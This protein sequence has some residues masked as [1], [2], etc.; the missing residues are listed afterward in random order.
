V[1]DPQN[2]VRNYT[3][4]ELQELLIFCVC[5]AGKSAATIAPRVDKLFKFLQVHTGGDCPL[6]YSYA[7]PLDLWSVLQDLGIGCYRM[8]ATAIK[9]VAE[10]ISYNELNLRTCTVEELEAIHG[11]GPKTA[12]AFIMWS[13]PNEQ[14]AILDTHILKWMK[15]QGIENVP[16]STPTGKNYARLEQE[17]LSRVPDGMTPAEF[18]LQIWKGYAN[19]QAASQAN[20]GVTTVY[21]K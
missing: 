18:D 20:T 6:D 2:I 5:V 16:K 3:D 4:E 11:I 17:F 1:I 19:K 9:E 12:K 7:L 8:K 10:L 21:A 14:H 15:E 13:R